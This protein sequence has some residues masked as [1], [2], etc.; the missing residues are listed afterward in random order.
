MTLLKKKCHLV[1]P[2]HLWPKKVK[3]SV[4]L[5]IS[6]GDTFFLVK[7]RTLLSSLP[8]KNGRNAISIIY[9]SER[10]IMS[11]L[12]ESLKLKNSHTKLTILSKRVFIHNQYS[13]RA[14]LFFDR[15]LT[16][17][18]ILTN[19]FLTDFFLLEEISY[20]AQWV[21]IF[22]KSVTFGSKNSNCRRLWW[23]SK[24]TLLKKKCH[25]VSPSVTFDL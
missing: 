8:F 9:S 22:I 16:P 2:S 13:Q 3:F 7:T 5:T 21:S 25:L 24:V 14:D 18:K 15:K 17:Y 1:S 4:I 10:M 19:F 23:F 6:K 11:I 12:N 20:E